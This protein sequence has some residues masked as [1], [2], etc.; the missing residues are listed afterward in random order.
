MTCLRSAGVTSGFS[1]EEDEEEK[2]SLRLE[3]EES[4]VLE[5][6]P[7]EEKLFGMRLASGWRSE[8]AKLFTFTK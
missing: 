6:F 4:F 8:L 2:G 1:D 5:A 7:L 3:E